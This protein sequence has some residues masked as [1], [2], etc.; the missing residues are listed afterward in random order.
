MS[1]DWLCQLPVN[2]FDFYYVDGSHV[3]PDVMADAVLGWRLLKPGGIMV[4]D[5]YEWG[6]Y[7]D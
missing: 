6:A 7:R 5:D 2:A 3:A 1:Q 4:F